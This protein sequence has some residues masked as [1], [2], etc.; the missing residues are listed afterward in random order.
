MKKITKRILCGALSLAMC[1]TLAV[2]SSLRLFADGG[3]VSPSTATTTATAPFTNVS[4]Q[5]DTSALRESMFNDT[6]L[7]AEEST[8]TYETR[9][10]I[11]TLSG[12]PLA[13]RT[14][15]EVK[16]YLETWSGDRAV[17][18]LNKEQED[19]LQALSRTGIPYSHKYSYN[20]VL[21]GVAIEVNTQYVSEIKKMKGVESVVITTAYAEPKT[22]N[23]SS[24][25]EVVTNETEVYATGIYDS[26]L[27]SYE[28]KFGEGT[29]VAVLDTGLDYTHDAFQGF[30]SENVSPAWSDDYVKGILNGNQLVAEKRAGNLELTDVY[31]SAKVPFTFDY[32]D[33]DP[34]VYPSYSNHGTHVAGIIGGYDEG[35]YTDKDG[36]PSP[37]GV[38]FRGVVP[39]AQLVICKVFTD[40]L[41]DPDLG[42][43][44]AEDIVAALNDCLT[45]GVDVINMSLGSSCGFTTTNDGDD[46]GDMLADV[47]ERIEKSGITLVCAAS[48][49]YS[50]GYGGVYGTNLA[51][52]P[53]SSTVGQPSTFA[54]ALS[55]ASINGQ[56]ASYIVANSE[57]SID[58]KSQKA[59]V[60]FEEA[61][62]INSN[63]FDFMKE[64]Q[65]KYGQS[66]FEYVVVPGVGHASDYRTVKHLFKNSDGTSLN[67]IALV[68]RGD[69]TFQE[70]V[71]AAKSSGAIGIIV[72]NNVA[73]TIRM[74]LGDINDPIP[75][76]SITMNAGIAM[77]DG[78]IKN[79]GYFEMDEENVAGP[80]MSE[81]S[82]WGPTH[83]LRLK[84][85]ITAHGGE[86]TSAVPGGYNEQSGTSM[87]TPNMAGFMAVA[88]KYIKEELGKTDAKEI[89]R[90]AMQLTMS[91]AGTVLDQDG[92]PYSPRK[93]GAGVAKLGNV[94]GGTKAYLWT[95]VAENDYRPKIE[96][97]DD[98]TKSGV[99][100]LNFKITNF[101][102]KTLTFTADQYMMTET[103]SKDRLTVSEQARLLDSRT[104]AWSVDGVP[105]G[106]NGQISVEAGATSSVKVVLT[107]SESD[108]KYMDD[109]FKNG[110]YVEGFAKLLSTDDEQCDLSI[111]FL[112]FYGDWDD[113]PM[114]DYTAYEIAENQQDD[115]VLEEDK[116]KASVWATQPYAMYY[117]EKYILPMGG[118]LY[119]L[120]DDAEPMY[121][122]QKYNSLS[123][124]NEYFGEGEPKNYMTSTGIKAV[125]AGLLRNARLVRYKLYD[126]STGEVLL[127]DSINRVG[128]AYTGGGNSVPANVELELIP[129]QL[130]LLANGQYKMTFEFFKDR[131][132]DSV[133]A[134]EDDT[135]EFTFTVDYEAP[136]LEGV[137]VRYDTYEEGGKT[138]QDI[139]LDVDVY[140]NHYA[141]ALLLCY[142]K[143]ASDGD[144]TL[145]LAT[146]YPTPI[147][148]SV[149]NGITT[150]SIEVTDIYEKYGEQL[151][152]QIDDYSLN[153]CLYQINLNQANADVLPERGQYELAAGEDNV[154][155]K[156]YETHKTSLVFG[157][158]YQGE[159]DLSNFLWTSENPK[160]AGVKKGEIVGLSAGTT[161]VFVSNRKGDTKTIN[162]TV[163][164]EKASLTTSPTISFGPI[165]TDSDALQSATGGIK[166]SAGENIKLSVLAD[167][168]Y[169]PMTG[170]RV[171]WSST[172]ESVAT[173]D[174][175]GNVVTKKK[176]MAVISAVVQQQITLSDGSTKWQDTMNAAQSVMSVQDPFTVSNYT[177]TKY[178]GPGGVVEIPSELNVMYIGAEAFKDNNNITE[179][180]IPSSVVDIRER[181]FYNCTALKEVYFVSKE[182]QA[183]ADADLAMVYEQAFYGC[184]ALEKIDLSNVKTVTVA[185]DCFGGCTN[186]KEVVDMPK[187]GTMHH[188]AF[189]GT[190]LTSVDLTGLHM[191]GNYVFE[192]CQQL[193]SVTTGKFTAIGNYMF[194]NCTNL[195]NEVVIST[196]KIGMGAFSGCVNLSGVKLDPAGQDI[197][198]DIGVKAFEDCGKNVKGSF[199]VEFEDVVI[200]SIGARA[201]AGSTL[202]SFAFDKMNGLEILGENAFA[203]TKLTEIALT[204]QM[205]FAMVRVTGV[206]FNNLT[207][208]VAEGA[209]KYVESDGVIYN[210]DGTAL[211]YVNGTK[212]GEFTLP[213]GVTTVANYAFANSK[214]SKVTLSNSVTTLGVGAFQNAKLTAIDFANSKVTAIP[215]GAFEGSTLTAIVLPDSVVSVGEYAFAGSALASFKGEQLRSIGSYAFANCAALT[216]IALADGVTEMGEA[217]FSECIALT[218]VTLPSVTQLGD[219]TFWGA[220]KLHT[221]TFG[222]TATTTG[223]Y[224]FANT[225]VV[226]VVLGGA[227]EVISEGAFYGCESLESIA[228][229]SAKEDDATS[230]T[231]TK[232]E[233]YAFEGCY[234]LKTVYGI[235]EVEDFGALSFYNTALT[236]LNLERATYISYMAFAT[237]EG[238]TPSYDTLSIPVAVT[239]ED[240][241]FFGGGES[242]VTLPASLKTLGAAAFA[243]SDKLAT[244]TVEEGNTAFFVVDGVLYRSTDE[245]GK[246]FE[247]VTYP[248][249]RVQEGE[250]GDRTYEVIEGT[251]RIQAYAFYRINN[252]NV[253]KVKLPYSVKAIGDSA[254][255][256]SGVKEYAF[257]SIEAPILEEV[258]RQEVRD[259]IS[260]QATIA[261]Y[262]G[263]FNTNFE[264]YLYRFTKYGKETSDMVMHYP[265]NGKGYDNPVYTTYF[266]TR[267]P[268]DIDMMEDE[269]RACVSFIEKTYSAEEIAAWAEWDKT[270]ENKAKVEGYAEE[271]RATRIRFND[272]SKKSG[273]AVYLTEAIEDKL[274]A[275]EEALRGVKD[276]F[277]I[278]TSISSLR[279]SENSTHKTE[280]FVGE[281][282]DATGLELLLVYDDFSME[283]ADG[284]KL[285]V[286]NADRELQTHNRTVTVKYVDGAISKQI[287][288]TIK[289][290]KSPVEEPPVDSGDVGDSTDSSVPDSDTSAPEKEEGKS[291]GCGG[292]VASNAALLGCL[293]LGATAIVM[294]KSKARK[295]EDE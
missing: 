17:A 11:V 72:W 4:G 190:A 234:K 247:L 226:N 67:R 36:N 211:L 253:N 148:N 260:A 85:E 50:S 225:P 221:V 121:V 60:F 143:T 118:Y 236:E 173:V 215:D 216:K 162:V 186:L 29:V 6:V 272:A 97:G 101:G 96:L 52:N 128:K 231:V 294:A 90:L 1:S 286:V 104:A 280:Y 200:R 82:S 184:T 38:E 35:G 32:A 201:F 153:T 209:S 213:S 106:E 30:K 91:T 147:R 111:P 287:T 271:V 127:S 135:F 243:D 164:E 259:V 151:Y 59:Y 166:V 171:Y 290:S 105:V 31:M 78:A 54:A 195:R 142:P 12:A 172:D 9:T 157:A 183:I 42:G 102:D 139:Y 177:L 89:N 229:P 199:Y 251:A 159:A 284:S 2:E 245:A 115:S 100:T 113:A 167:P 132:D 75:A 161:R 210:Q 206:P 110:M 181:A 73:G 174:Q 112:G 230:K 145:Q 242:S 274:L 108:K 194:K 214:I 65:D 39:D 77:R 25:N 8:A 250:A 79:V 202:S 66:R 14:D 69:T 218:E 95:D 264:T 55:V 182:K 120:P 62:D 74:N 248:T 152:I 26:S 57:V 269:T 192:N 44:V 88:R 130:G 219:Y 235:E 292:N 246:V 92:L 134:P 15:G 278:P 34:D 158:D 257:E 189:A 291:G 140:D 265:L 198:F 252:G 149:K 80:F 169:H 170:L 160:I 175:E 223:K 165:Q 180:I 217:V 133:T 3:S 87:A 43:A 289:V 126:E 156:I 20:A 212:T 21:N 205:D 258:Y 40:D 109:S 285:T 232:I 103:L 237:Q 295:G 98:P 193:R 283:V 137:R 114:L 23:A 262:K 155:L 19:F 18:Q 168:W 86:I 68:K 255:F 268:S 224:T 196:P 277:D 56:K 94:V 185:A 129:E 51:V 5:F 16:G 123:R 222:A 122:E 138:K 191:S 37:A 244:I 84:P 45:L 270:S 46:E 141:Q 239:I 249:A 178:N 33:D 238:R 70:K 58:D 124:Y 99:Y 76:I 197:K 273:Q 61:R 188:R 131:V 136:T 220:T 241:A 119:E 154:S 107:V 207:V 49:D 276:A 83:D 233:A 288:L 176:G 93:Q 64:M 254:F 150:V 163:S 63:P 240:Y 256:E 282:F 267:I 179:I 279:V 293:A 281:K 263:Y 71:E 266:G 116:I 22:A 7:E 227:T 228:L 275:V 41:D 27:S 208:T 187:I 261:E 10:V 117:N 203:N 28:G 47:Y 81:F 13:D 146:E 48:N 204:D 125:Y 24:T 53:D 144:V